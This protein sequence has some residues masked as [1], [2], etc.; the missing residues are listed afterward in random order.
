M[1]DVTHFF[2]ILSIVPHVF[3]RRHLCDNL[4]ATWNFTP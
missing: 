2:I 4:Y 3:S 1:C